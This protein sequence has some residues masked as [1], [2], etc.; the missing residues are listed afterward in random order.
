MAGR[1]LRLNE[2]AEGV[3]EPHKAVQPVQFELTDIKGHFDQSLNRVRNQYEVADSLKQAG[4]EEDCKNIWR[5]QIVFLEGILD[6]YLHEM[7]KYC[8]YK[9]F[10]GE[11]AKSEQYRSLQIPMI[12]VE[13]GIA[14]AE[15]KEWFFR[16]LNE[17]FSRDVFLSSESMRQQLNLI[18]VKYGEVMHQAFR[19]DTINES[20]KF[21]D[22]VVQG[23]FKRRNAIAHQLDRDHASAEQTDI[24]REF[25]EERASEVTAIVEAIHKIAV[26]KG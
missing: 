9:M 22:R 21:G 19:K 4:K 17:R 3:R 23:L 7:S 8:L 15:S 20:Q 10:K 18:G 12:K 24:T 25:V 14:A 13:E 26:E 11:W 2:R 5:S 16:Y 6:F 1:N